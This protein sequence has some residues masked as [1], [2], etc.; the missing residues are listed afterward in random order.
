M[1]GIYLNPYKYAVECNIPID[2]AK[3]ACKKYR[4][5]YKEQR[6]HIPRCPKCGS[7][8]LEVEY[9]SYEEGYDGF[10]TC[11]SCDEAF[12]FNEIGNIKYLP[13]YG[14]YFD[15]VLYFASYEDKKQGWLEACGTET[16]E[17]WHRF[18]EDMIIG[19]KF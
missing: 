12:D 7:K 14:D 4:H 3:I 16:L 18:A 5:F 9:G 6:K 1:S 8:K 10:I 15:A 13:Y 19:I 11:E 2:L 17:G